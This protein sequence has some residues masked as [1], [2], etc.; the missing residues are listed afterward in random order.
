MTKRLLKPSYTKH[1]KIQAKKHD[2]QDAT[3]YES[4]T[5]CEARLGVAAILLITYIYIEGGEL[6][7]SVNGT[8]N[9]EVCMNN[10]RDLHQSD[11]HYILQNQRQKQVHLSSLSNFVNQSLSS[12]KG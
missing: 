5:S 7:Y 2:L 3:K 12:F 10:I 6:G 8:S 4:K 11:K 9:K 1:N